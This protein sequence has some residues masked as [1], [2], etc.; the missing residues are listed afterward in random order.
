MATLKTR[1]QLQRLFKSGDKPS[2]EDF[3]DLIQSSLNVK[4]DG[5]EKP[6]GTDNPLKITV[7]GDQENVLDLYAGQTHTWRLNQKPVQ[8]AQGLNLETASGTSKLFLE[9]SSGNLGLGTV[10]PIAKVH[11]Q[12]QDLSNQHALRIDDEMG[13]TTPLVVNADGNVG[14]G[15]DDPTNPLDV[16]GNTRI[17]GTLSVADSVNLSR[18]AVVFAENGQIQ[19]Q[20]ETHQISFSGKGLEL[21]DTGQI[22]F[23]PG[24]TGAA[25]DQMV[26]DT[27][28]NLTVNGSGTLNGTGTIKGDASIG[29]QLSIGGNTEVSGALNITENT[30]ILGALTVTGNTTVTGTLTV[31]NTSLS[32]TEVVFAETGQIRVKDYAHRISF[33]TDGLELRDTGKIVF[34]PGETDDAANHQMVLDETGNLTVNGSERVM[35]DANVAGQLKVTGATS[36]G[37]N[38][39]VSGTTELGYAQEVIDFSDCL[40]SGFYQGNK[41][42][43]DVADTTDDLSH[44]INVRHNDT[45]KN[46]QLQIAGTYTVNDRLFFRK[47]KNSQA[48]SDTQSIWHELATRGANTFN[49]TQIIKGVLDATKIVGEGAFVV[50]MIIMWSGKVSEIPTG[51]VLCD[52]KNDT[53]DLTER[54]I[55]GAGASYEP[56][57]KGDPDSHSHN[58][59]PPK[60]DTNETGGHSHKFPDNWG[61]DKFLRGD[62]RCIKKGSTSIGDQ[63]TQDAETHSHS[64][65]IAEFESSQSASLNRPKW[66]ALCFIIKI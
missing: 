16:N 10:K 6:A 25:T 65:D 63:T 38:L 5:I 32:A 62:I 59:N 13:D 9:S 29:G 61:N 56:G 4:D 18:N 15:M 7:N 26:L 41:P 58:V 20:D 35:G 8:T 22:V 30:Q 55:V 44:L 21:R 24:K 57:D 39:S 19:S 40:A 34:S 31:A 47:I 48:I 50:G 37:G 14:I 45:G 53:P 43:G 28:G 36:L 2:E 52:G 54:F 3:K 12:L 42:E 66:Y 1:D 27:Q 33:K 17:S 60:T 64:V 46:V 11:I 23:S 51:W 49:G